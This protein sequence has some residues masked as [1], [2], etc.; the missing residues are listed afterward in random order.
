LDI[1]RQAGYNESVQPLVRQII[2]FRVLLFGVCLVATA[3][4][5]PISRQI[6]FDQSTRSMFDADNPRLV[7]YERAVA[8]FGGDATCLAGYS[9]PELL[10]AEG[11]ARL[12]SF[13][14]RIKR[15][16]GV[17][18]AT[19]LADLPRPTAPFQNRKLADWFSSGVSADELRKEIL[20]TDLYV[21]QFVGRDGRTAAV[22]ITLDRSAMAS[23]AIEATLEQL[24]SIAEQNPQPAR[25]VGAPVMISDTYRLLAED[26]W[27]LTTISNLAML[28]VIFFLFRSIRW[29]VLPL[30]IV[31]VT[32][33]WTRALMALTDVQL[34]VIGSM[35]TALVT[36]IGI[37]TTIHIAV[38]YR[39]ESERAGEGADALER[40][41]VRVAPA[42]IWTCATTSAGFAS[43]AVSR[44]AP[45]R[46][47]A[48]V[49]AFA[50]LFVGLA[51]LLLVPGGALI[52]RLRSAPQET[53]GEDSLASGLGRGVSFVVRHSIITSAAVLAGLTVA[54]VGFQ[55]LTVETDFTNNFRQSSPILA[56]Y[57]FVERRLGGAGVVELAF[58]AP[59]PLTPEFLE[60]VR[61][62]E[63]RL[64][65]LPGVTK[66]IGL[67]DFLELF[68]RAAPIG[69]GAL[70]SLLPQSQTLQMKL[71]LLRFFKPEVLRGV[72][73]EGRGRMRLVLRVREQQ[74][75]AAKRRLV[76]S[77]EDVARR[78]LG[79]EA[80]VTGL[81]VLLV[82][83][84]DRLLADQWLT[85]GVSA[86]A[87]LLMATAAFR[88]FR[89]GLVAFLPNVVPMVVV[90]GTMGWLA[91]PVNVATAMI[92]AISMGLVVDFGIHY[93]NRFRQERAAGADFYQALARTHRSTGKAMVFANVALTLGFSVLVFS[94]FVPTIHFG[95][96]VSV[97]IVGG[98]VGNLLLLPI[99][100]RLTLRERPSG[101]PAQGQ[102]PARAPTG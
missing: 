65:E 39:E 76:E 11:L 61:L 37:A 50:S 74:T 73:N 56:G 101:R 60:K 102:Q 54:A 89:F 55:W 90:L 16:P 47:F 98:L 6:Q 44:V 79:A 27:V 57:R 97:A 93:L 32:L 77:I 21:D 63:R 69:S 24:R 59:E 96:L 66:V 81:Y 13:T 70:A 78:T 12:E 20:Q 7:T 87:I 30:A 83:L 86:T 46:D 80:D 52:G 72:W 15:V 36:V 67:S 3:L 68:D 64:R 41:L 42:V 5:Y 23:G 48:F 99:L 2:R 1:P 94:N 29:V 34:S 85:F 75:M 17:E 38:R 58:D 18:S 28:G 71:R 82:F 49:M 84:I 9:D 95:L 35:T 31:Q 10:T 26:S 40:A 14:E 91:L 25:L 53:P 33:V 45:V 51:S 43:L 19:S 100:L 62:C 8:Q 4:L 22:L 88:S 92:G